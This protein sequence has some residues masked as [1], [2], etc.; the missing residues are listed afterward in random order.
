MEEKREHCYQNYEATKKHQFL[1]I[2]K[3]VVPISIV[4]VGSI[5][6]HAN[7]HLISFFKEIFR[8]DLFFFT[9]IFFHPGSGPAGGRDTQTIFNLLKFI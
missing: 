3:K 9:F 6:Q 4:D 7:N 5:N 2:S 1:T 8:F